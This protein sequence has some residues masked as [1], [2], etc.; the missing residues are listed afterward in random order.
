MRA[1]FE[2]LPYEEGFDQN[3]PIIEVND[4]EKQYFQR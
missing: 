1:S 3:N 2:L 4:Y